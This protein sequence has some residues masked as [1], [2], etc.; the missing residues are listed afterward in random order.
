MFTVFFTLTTFYLQRLIKDKTSEISEELENILDFNAI[1]CDV[2]DGSKN[3]FPSQY[4][5][6]YSYY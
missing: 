4:L 5:L 1:Q 2:E 3:T 6:I